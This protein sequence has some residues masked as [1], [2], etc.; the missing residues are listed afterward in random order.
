[1]IDI[2][3]FIKVHRSFIINLSNI[4]EIGESDLYIRN[5]NIYFSTVFQS[6]LLFNHE[7]IENIIVIVIR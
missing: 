6:V 2:P 5:T 7:L 3:V 1:M 4:E